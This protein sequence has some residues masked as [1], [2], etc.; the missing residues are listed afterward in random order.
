MPTCLIC[1]NG[2]KSSWYDPQSFCKSCMERN[3]E[4]FNIVEN[5]E[6]FKKEIG[7]LFYHE[8]GDAWAVD[9]QEARFVMTRWGIWK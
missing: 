4:K 7:S 1:G 3:T 6:R 9:P 8:I 2:I 5:V